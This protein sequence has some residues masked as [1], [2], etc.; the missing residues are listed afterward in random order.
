M[1]FKPTPL[2][3]FSTSAFYL[4][5]FTKDE[6]ERITK[7]AKMHPPKEAMTGGGLNKEVRTTKLT[8]LEYNEFTAWIF[9]RIAS[10][11]YQCNNF[12]WRFQLSGFHEGLQFTN[13]GKGAFYSWHQDSGGGE[14]S[15]RKLS[16]VVQLTAPEEYEGGEL[17]FGGSPD[18]APKEQGA[19][20]FFPSYMP[21]QVKPILSGVR[22]SL[23][24]WISG[25]PY[26]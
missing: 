10:I 13:Y 15:I 4:K 1:N 26:R 23:V 5:V 18:P 21:H 20:I 14:F 12:R 8:F 2:E 9:E 6:C 25:E 11:A 22:N 19:V 17:E 16:V 7:F 24:A 3:N